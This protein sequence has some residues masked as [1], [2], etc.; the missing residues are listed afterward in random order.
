MLRDCEIIKNAVDK[1]AGLLWERVDNRE[2]QAIK[3]RRKK[4]LAF[5]LKSARVGI[6]QV[7][8]LAVSGFRRPAS[9]RVF[10]F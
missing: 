2:F 10:C 1:K 8:A 9:R 7:A 4:A 6:V 3:N 5:F